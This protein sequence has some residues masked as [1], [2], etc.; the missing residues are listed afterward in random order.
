MENQQQIS[1]AARHIIGPDGRRL[2]Q[3]EIAATLGIPQSTA[4]K[5]MRGT[6]RMPTHTL[7]RLWRA[8][9]VG[10]ELAAEWSRILAARY[11][12]RHGEA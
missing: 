2:T 7:V 1:C 4:D 3:K 12:E 10:P 9:D 8:Y 11:E 6:T 5:M